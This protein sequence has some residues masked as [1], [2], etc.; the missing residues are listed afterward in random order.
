MTFYGVQS[1]M[2]YWK[3]QTS[4][5][6]N[7]FHNLGKWSQPEIYENDV[8]SSAPMTTREVQNTSV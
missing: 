8:F 5:I 6:H 7:N 3:Q 1:T 4:I 2:I